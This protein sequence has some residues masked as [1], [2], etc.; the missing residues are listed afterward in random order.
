V[1]L[2]QLVFG[3]LVGHQGAVEGVVFSLLEGRKTSRGSQLRGWPEDW[4]FLEDHPN[5]GV[6][7]HQPVNVR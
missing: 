6:F 2:G 1:R 4:E 3:R 5:I 7:L